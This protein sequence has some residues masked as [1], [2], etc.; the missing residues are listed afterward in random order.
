MP[1]AEQR[2]ADLERENRL[3]RGF[4]VAV[5]Q[6]P[7]CIVITD[8]QGKMEY[9]NPRFLELTG[10]SAAEALG[11]NPSILKSGFTPAAE[12]EALWATITSGR[13]WRGEFCN[14][15]KNG[16]PYWESAAIAP[17]V[18][19]QGNITHFVAVK[20]EITE[21]KRAERDLR[22]SEER[23]RAL[24]EQAHDCIFQLEIRPGE[25]PVILDVNHAG[26]RVL[27]YERE[28][29]LGQPVS[30]LSQTLDSNLPPNVEQQRAVS[31]E[32]VSF[33]TKHQCKDGTI[34]DFECSVRGMRIGAKT[35][36]VSIERDITERKRAEEAV[37]NS[38]AQ[39]RAILD[40]TPF[41]I[42][43]VDVEGN[44]IEFWSRSA[45]TLF[46]H[47]APTARE[48]YLLAYPDPE[49][50]RQVIERWNAA[51]EGAR[52]SG[53]T[54][55]AGEY[56]V[57]CRDGSTRD[58]ELYATFLMNRLVV[59]FNDITERKRAESELRSA[60]DFVHGVV[61]TIADPVFVKDDQRRYMLVNDAFC[62]I[63]GHPREELLAGHGDDL[64]P[65]EEAAL[66]RRIDD[67]VLDTGQ[68]NVNEEFLSNLSKGEVRTIVTRKTRYIDPAG[69]RFLVGVIRDI[70]ASKQAGIALSA[71]EERYRMLFEKS[72]D[73]LMTLAP[74]S[75]S[76]TSG[77]PATA[78]LFG[79]GSEGEFVA[80]P[81]W[82]YSPEQQPDGRASADKAKEMIETAMREGSHFFEWTHRRASGEDFPATVLLN[83]IDIEGKSFLQATVRDESERVRQ[84]EELRRAKENAEAATQAK[85]EFLANMSHEIRT[86]M[87]AIIGFGHLLLRAELPPRQRDQVSKIKSSA[88]SLL[89][90][91]NNILDLS[92]IEAG[93]VDLEA[94]PF[95]LDQVLASVTDTL[96]GKVAEKDLEMHLQ[97]APKVP[98]A[99]VGDGKRLGQ[100]LLNL[101]GNAVKFTDQGNVVVSVELVSRAGSTARLRCSVKDTGPGIAKEVA[102]KLF[103]P[104]VQA[105]SS[106]TRRF[107]G[108]GLGLA[109]SR[110][111]VDLM[112]GEILLD[113][114]PGMGSTFSFTIA[115]GLQEQSHQPPRRAPMDL[116][117][118]RV[119]VVDDSPIARMVLR[120][121][122]DAMSFA[123]TTA[124]SGPDGIAEVAA[125]QPP[126]DLVLLDWH[127]PGMD[128][129]ETARR[130][131]ALPGLSRVP[132]MMMLTTYDYDELARKAADLGLDGFL[133][134]PFT[135]SL[136]LDAIM[137]AFGR[138]DLSASHADLTAVPGE[139]PSATL[140]GAR[141]L[142]VE[143]NQLNQMVGQALLEGMGLAVELAAN[144]EQ[145]V[146]MIDAGRDRFDAVLMDVQM[147]VM[148]GD[149][150]TRALRKLPS[151]ADLPI[152]AVTAN[153]L[154]SER[155]RCLEAG[156]NDYVSKPIDPDRLRTVLERWVPP[157]R[158]PHPVP[159]SPGHFGSP[160][161]ASTSR[162]FAAPSP[163]ARGEETLAAPHPVPLP[164][165][166]GEGTH[167]GDFAQGLLASPL[168]G[169]AGARSASG[170][171]LLA[172][173][174]GGEAGARSASGE[175]LPASPLGGE[176]GARSA[177][178]EELLASPLGGEAGARSASGEGLLAS[179]LG[180]EAGARSAS[181][182][183][184]PASPLGG[185]AGARSA[186]GEGLLASPLGGEA[187]A[188]SASGEGLPAS[189]LGGEAGA[190]SASGEGLLASPLGGEAGARSA[191]G[192][193][194]PASPLGGEAGARSASGEGLPASPLG[195]EAGARSA[196]GE[197]L[198]ASLP[199][200][201][202]RAAL[203]RLMGNRELLFRLLRDFAS[204]HGGDPEHI[205]ALLARGDLD[206][207]RAA[208]HRLKGV[209]GNLAA[210]Q[211]FAS[212]VALESS[213]R[214]GDPAP[215]EAQVED[216]ANA[217]RLVTESVA[218]LATPAPN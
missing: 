44:Q 126:Y 202:T 28:E 117:G 123:V 131:K 105:D 110:Q 79:A 194:L 109:I 85:S 65:K 186:S 154:S 78:A 41:P 98:R 96:S 32:G 167:G 193:G 174:L 83:R 60:R 201:D 95:D 134:K 138:D 178:G 188:R 128:G 143:D 38:E 115:V 162:G 73:A 86:P 82:H 180:G 125:A 119:L 144:G 29:L 135:D 155:D 204:E 106:T 152:I 216:L 19:D 208:I 192:E 197:G 21:R 11:Q 92:R 31:K 37:R 71:S 158:A 26:I 114:T 33:E 210:Q 112:G 199:G 30:F 156:M 68:E 147:P 91:I 203:G 94:V 49:Y 182:E 55:H 93:K 58:C 81:P 3:L 52:A 163:A 23:F 77:N 184:L 190:R 61:N 70:T 54:V 142:L 217:M 43:L 205:R 74:P 89:E 111:L 88:H 139:Q 80:R 173:P 51:I 116:R 151:T 45:L 50:R 66:F 164:A 67:G 161:S 104:F 12:Y 137:G 198:L 133:P 215:F 4:S 53:Q 141:V 40:A 187:G 196:S 176:A 108:S 42:A 195:G 179:P 20:H 18:D 15:K 200:V 145:A 170:E 7:A 122:L 75:W 16:E 218:S 148:D 25:S 35:I 46:G 59:T 5:E 160:T 191:S 56:R 47:T 9:V 207:A 189:P 97:V 172:S 150:A 146:A 157:R 213:L 84:Q 8:R 62:A 124:S 129:L 165:T 63:M 90:L 159:L 171:G 2:I 103:Q 39:L 13:T 48:W 14:R 113:S 214:R 212:A 22:E 57:T 177:S 132:R 118:L 211:V 36:A 153:A 24:F 6:S 99:L 168:G 175:G 181:G 136:L 169:E 34:R 100:V 69:R 17:I 140:A 206:A 1:S 185:E 107:G 120:D 127:M 76:F 209:A 166:R 130:V 27:G 87:N 149:T 183:G 102:E 72:R 10:Y 64:L 121:S 101:A